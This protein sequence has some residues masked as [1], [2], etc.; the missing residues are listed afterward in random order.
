MGAIGRREV[1][2]KGS[3]SGVDVS[4]VRWQWQDLHMQVA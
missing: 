2:E 4:H 3:G 1:A